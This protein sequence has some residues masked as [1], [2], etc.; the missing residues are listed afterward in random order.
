MNLIKM[1]I[2]ILGEPNHKLKPQLYI[3]NGFK[4]LKLSIYQLEGETV[5]YTLYEGLKVQFNR[6]LTCDVF[7]YYRSRLQQLTRKGEDNE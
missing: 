6:E 3:W 2:K 7:L 5:K 1:A 4:G